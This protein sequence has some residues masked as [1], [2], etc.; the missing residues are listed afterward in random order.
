LVS[1]VAPVITEAVVTA[2]AVGIPDTGHEMLAPIAT[3]AG[4]AGVQIPTV[5]PAG[6]PETA[7]V[8]FAAAAVADA[9]FVHKMVP[10]YATPTVAVAGRPARSG[11]ISE[12][13]MLIAV[14]D[15]LPIGSLIDVV[16]PVIG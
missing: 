4:A 10:L 14:V 7:H 12:P 6:R 5:T 11:I 15:V 2:G 9:L 3:L 16:V 1:L 13:V 8:A